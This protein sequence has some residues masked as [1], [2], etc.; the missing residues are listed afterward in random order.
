M[1]QEPYIPYEI[2][3]LALIYSVPLLFI[4]G[5]VSVIYGQK[6]MGFLQ[7]VVYATSILF[8]SHI[9]KDNT[10]R[11]VDMTCA[12]LLLIWGTYVSTYYLPSVR[13]IWYY[14]LGTSLCVFAAN[15]AVFFI[16]I[17]FCKTE[18]W[19][20]YMTYQAVIIHMIFLHI[21]PVFTG[22]YCVIMGKPSVKYMISSNR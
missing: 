17:G 10:I 11:H 14:S 15:E 8:W 4:G 6:I 22:I 21:L 1:D 12:T 19:R 7:F 5:L 16:G 9:G 18:E 3:D 13:Y 20:T 2:S